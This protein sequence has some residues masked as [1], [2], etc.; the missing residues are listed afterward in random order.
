[1]MGQRL[2]AVQR[3]CQAYSRGGQDLGLP[4]HGC[5]SP[6]QKGTQP[7]GSSGQGS[8]A[9][10]AQASLPRTCSGVQDRH[11]SSTLVFTFVFPM[12]D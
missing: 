2:R 7:R 11:S 8:S 10:S 9:V 5:L 6:G 1:M 3:P 12:L 4:L